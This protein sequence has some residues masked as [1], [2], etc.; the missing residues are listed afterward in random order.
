[1]QCR[2]FFFLLPALL[3]AASVVLGADSDSDRAVKLA[4][5]AEA[6]SSQAAIARETAVN[7]VRNA[8]AVHEDA[9][10]A[11]VEAMRT[12][13]P[14]AMDARRKALAR[15]QDGVEEAIDAALDTVTLATRAQKSAVAAKEYANRVAKETEARSI[16]KAL[17]KARRHLANA[18]EYADEALELADEL[19]EEWLAPSSSVGAPAPL[20]TPAT[21]AGSGKTGSADG[22]AR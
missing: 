17:K 1:M 9:A 14:V 22:E 15:A 16:A 10:A 4:A 19:K 20:A 18:E 6:A 2:R 5:S 13:D 21:D 12:S 11:L 8:V 3:V 7:A